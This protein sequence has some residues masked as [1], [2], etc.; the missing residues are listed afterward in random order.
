[1]P[2]HEGYLSERASPLLRPRVGLKLDRDVATVSEILRDND[3]HTVMSGKWHLGWKEGFLPHNRGF[4]RSFVMVPGSTNHFGWEPHFDVEQNGRP[5]K[6]LPGHSLPLYL[7][8]GTR[9]RP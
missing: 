8:D 4:D 9:W 7:H 6:F 1:M 2:G 3:Y 5:K